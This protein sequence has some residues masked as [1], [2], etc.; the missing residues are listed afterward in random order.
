[1]DIKRILGKRIQD[2][3]KQK[4]FT[5]DKLAEIIG[6]DTISLSKIE[7][8]RNYP[9]AEN[10]SKIAKILEVDIYELFVTDGIKSNEELLNEIRND[11]NKISKDNKKLHILYTTLKALAG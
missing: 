3:R 8:G 1:M 4:N 5:Q 9:T 2:Y 7:T 6:I 10:L 11:L